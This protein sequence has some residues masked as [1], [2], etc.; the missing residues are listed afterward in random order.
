MNTTVM[1]VDDDSISLSIIEE[2]LKQGG[3]NSITT[4]K[5]ESALEL[6]IQRHPD[7]IIIDVMMPNKSGLELCKDFKLNPITKDIPIMLLS[8]STDAEHII[9]SLHLGCVD[10]VRKPVAMT[11]LIDIIYKHDV[12]KKISEVWQPAK[13]E[14]ER[15]IRKY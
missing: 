10:Y 4:S 1:I 13:R 9:A 5:P 2:A 14:L 15:L 6:A 8:S 11:D 12:I 7:F 3:Y